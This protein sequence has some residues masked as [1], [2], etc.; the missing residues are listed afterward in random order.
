MSLRQLSVAEGGEAEAARYGEAQGGAVA[1]VVEEARD[2][3]LQLEIAELQLELRGRAPR[4]VPPNY[5]A[6]KGR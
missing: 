6:S 5:L 2:P 3:E 4:R 1:W